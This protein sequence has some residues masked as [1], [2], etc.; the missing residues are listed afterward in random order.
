MKKPPSVAELLAKAQKP[1]EEAL[2]LHPF[3]RGKLAVTPK[4]RIRDLDDF[5]IWYTPIVSRCYVVRF[6]AL[7]RSQTA[8][9]PRTPRLRTPLP[10]R[11]P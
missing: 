2:R 8:P 11:L 1:S 9:E 6:S 5:A 7:L 10:A 4:C 3:Y